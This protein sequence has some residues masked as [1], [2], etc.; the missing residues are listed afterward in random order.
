MDNLNF[1]QQVAKNILENTLNKGCIA[2][3]FSYDKEMKYPKTGA[4]LKQ[5]LEKVL[6]DKG[7]MLKGLVSSLES[8]SGY[9]EK[10]PN[11]VTPDYYFENKEE[12]LKICSGLGYIYPDKMCYLD[13]NADSTLVPRGMV[14]LDTE[15][16]NTKEIADACRKYNDIVR[17]CCDICRDLSY[18]KTMLN[19]VKDKQTYQLTISQLRAL[20]F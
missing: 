15:A 3:S 18:A 10:N 6:I 16:A 2:D 5:Q 4:E 8:L 1:K 13:S 7:E 19:N 12:A 9:I 14:Q 20:N 17:K 11:Y